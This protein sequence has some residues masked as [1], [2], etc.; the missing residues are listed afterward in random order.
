MG[1]KSGKGGHGPKLENKAASVV[2]VN[3]VIILVL[4]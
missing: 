2:P 4:R 3:R 1:G